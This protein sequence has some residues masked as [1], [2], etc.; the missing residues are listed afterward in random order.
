[1]TMIELAFATTKKRGNHT[2]LPQLC[3]PNSAANTIPA[4]SVKTAAR[5]SNTS[6][7]IE[8]RLS[9][10]A[11]TVPQTSANAANTAA[12]IAQ[13]TPPG[14]PAKESSMT[15]PTKA[16]SKRVKRN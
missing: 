9:T 5:M 11:A 15:F 12:A 10:K 13:F 1:M 14:L 6:V 4:M 16:R 7:T 3:T 8:G 2:W